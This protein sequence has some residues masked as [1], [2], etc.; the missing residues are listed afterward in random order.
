MFF[1]RKFAVGLLAILIHPMNV[2]ASEES[3]RIQT[4]LDAIE[5]WRVAPEAIL[6]YCNRLLP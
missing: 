4:Q 1:F 6:R 5:G 2:S 3:Y